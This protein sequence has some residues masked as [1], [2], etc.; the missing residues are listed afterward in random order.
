MHGMVISV[1]ISSSYTGLSLSDAEAS[2]YVIQLIDG[3]IYQV[4]P[5]LLE[6][7]VTTPS[8]SNH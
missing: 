3:S 6:Q 7:F 8:S 5:D 4:S 1:P 2:P